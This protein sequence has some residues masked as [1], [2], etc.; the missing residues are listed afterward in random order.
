MKGKSIHRVLGI[1]CLILG[2]AGVV[3]GVVDTIV[4]QRMEE[5]FRETED[6]ASWAG[7]SMVWGSIVL[8]LGIL[9]IVIT[10]KR[11]S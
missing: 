3:M 5:I 4:D 2:F 9:L 8:A 6:V 7:P 1:G 10:E 11:S